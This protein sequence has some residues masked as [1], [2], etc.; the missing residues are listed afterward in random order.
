MFNRKYII[1]EKQSL[2]AV[3]TQR[4]NMLVA[5]AI[6][7]EDQAKR[8]RTEGSVKRG[9]TVSGENFFLLAC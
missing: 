3:L 2:W 9:T 4:R 1:I 5:A 8:G 7:D 6:Y